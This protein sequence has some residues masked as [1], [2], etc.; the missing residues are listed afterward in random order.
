MKYHDYSPKDTQIIERT[1]IG[2]KNIKGEIT[3]KVIK[4]KLSFL[5]ATHCHDLFYITVKY[6]K[7]IPNLIQVI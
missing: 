2:I 4:R 3:K 7:N 1:L 5:Y 6:Y